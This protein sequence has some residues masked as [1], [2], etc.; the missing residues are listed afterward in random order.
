MQRVRSSNEAAVTNRLKAAK[1]QSFRP[2]SPINS[3]QFLTVIDA[4]FFYKY[5]SIMSVRN[6]TIIGSLIS[7]T[8]KASPSLVYLQTAKTQLKLENRRFCI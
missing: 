3:I 6:K 5:S 1:T 7:T 8:L 4:D 2:S